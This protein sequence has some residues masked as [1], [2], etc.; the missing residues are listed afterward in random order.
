MRRVSG[1]EEV[2]VPRNSFE[3]SLRVN[4]L[5]DSSDMGSSLASTHGLPS[6]DM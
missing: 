1:D 4:E 5:S 2:G 6:R 3:R